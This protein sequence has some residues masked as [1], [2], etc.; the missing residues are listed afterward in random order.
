MDVCANPLVQL[1]IY[2]QLPDEV[3]LLIPDHLLTPAASIKLLRSEI[4][5]Y[6]QIQAINAQ[7]DFPEL[8]KGNFHHFQNCE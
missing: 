7:L 6:K 2:N 8:P 4:E 3:K 1:D 5:W